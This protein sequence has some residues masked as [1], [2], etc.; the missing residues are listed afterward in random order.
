M[1]LRKNVRQTGTFRPTP[2]MG[3]TGLPASPSLDD[4]AD[5]T[6]IHAYRQAGGNV[7]TL[8]GNPPAHYVVQPVRTVAKP[9]PTFLRLLETPPPEET[10]DPQAPDTS[11]G[12]HAPDPLLGALTERASAWL[13]IFAPKAL[14]CLLAARGALQRE[15]AESLAHAALS[16]RRG[17]ISLADAVE[18]AGTAPRRDH[19]GVE[20]EVGREQFKNRLVIY[21][22]RTNL[23]RSQRA[24]TLAELSL[25]DEQLARH[26]RALGKGIHDDSSHDQ[27]MQ[28]YMTA[29]S[30]FVQ[31]CRC[32]ETDTEAH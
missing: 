30:V 23:D 1:A 7:R 8:A 12:R 24:L 28:L 2:G 31:V 9:T 4:L 32:A 29:W 22:G 10:Q 15:G 25:V 13:Q 16:L 17:M 20:R 18:P 27:L 5:P 11:Q 19:S 21:L 26:A 3:L 6:W 14:E